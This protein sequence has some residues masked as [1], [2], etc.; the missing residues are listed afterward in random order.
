M[1]HPRLLTFEPHGDLFRAS[2]GS[3]TFYQASE[4]RCGHYRSGVMAR[5]IRLAREYGAA[6]IA[7]QMRGKVVI[8]VGANVG[9]FSHFALDYEAKVY[10]IEPDPL[11]FAALKKNMKGR[12]VKSHRL[13]LWKENASLPLTLMTDSGDS[14][15][16]P[17]GAESTLM[18]KGVTL[19]RFMDVMK[20]DDVFLLKADCEGAEP[21]MLEGAGDA[22]QRISYICI[23]CGPERY[24]QTTVDECTEIL[25]H[26][27]FEVSRLKQKRVVLFCKAKS[28]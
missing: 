12:G 25:E 11:A 28:I 5:C 18:V 7:P 20:L 17:I 16:L 8:D 13:A 15:V 6:S 14:N 21:E 4:R 24:R 27:G 3:E 22:L 1:R 9:E 2:I 26:H 23:D 10:A 19:K